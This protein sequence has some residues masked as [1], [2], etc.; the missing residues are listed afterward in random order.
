MLEGCLVERGLSTLG[1]SRA[2][3]ILLEM[4]ATKPE[5]ELEAAA[6]SSAPLGL[7]HRLQA[8]ISG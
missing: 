1:A 6:L 8:T 3:A 4:V 7:A 5:D 2:V